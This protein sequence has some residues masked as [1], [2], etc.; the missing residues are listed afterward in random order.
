MRPKNNMI[1]RARCEYEDG[2]GYCVAFLTAHS[3][4]KYMHLGLG[5]PFTKNRKCVPIR[6]S[7]THN[8]FSASMMAVNLS[9]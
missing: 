7:Y 5:P 3:V 9:A 2:G 8:N 4:L 1:A 6:R